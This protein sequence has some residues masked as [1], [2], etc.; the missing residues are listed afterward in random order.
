MFQLIGKYWGSLHEA[1]ADSWGQRPCCRAQGRTVVTYS[2]A[3]ASAWVLLTPL[4]LVGECFGGVL[5]YKWFSA[6]GSTQAHLYMKYCAY[7]KKD[8]TVRKAFI[9]IFIY[10]VFLTDRLIYLCFNLAGFE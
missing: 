10:P 6:L 7:H 2:S 3:P 8:S 4:S 5:F 9:I 1:G